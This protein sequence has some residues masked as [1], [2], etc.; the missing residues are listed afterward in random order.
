MHS[1]TV[2]LDEPILRFEHHLNNVPD[3]WDWRKQGCVGPV[4][5]QGQMGDNVPIVATGKGPAYKYP[6]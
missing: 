2:T 1:L 4:Q 3:A 5:D 6:R